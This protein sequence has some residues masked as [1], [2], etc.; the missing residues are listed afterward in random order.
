MDH[1]HPTSSSLNSHSSMTS[2]AS[3][4]SLTTSSYNTVSGMSSG[5]TS[6]TSVGS[7][8]FKSSL[9]SSKFLLFW[10][11]S[12]M[13]MKMS[14]DLPVLH[15]CGCFICCHKPSVP[16]Y[17]KYVYISD[18]DLACWLQTSK[19]LTPEIERLWLFLSSVS[20]LPKWACGCTWNHELSHSYCMCAHS[21]HIIAM[22]SLHAVTT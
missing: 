5:L 14:L 2:N 9:T 1:S 19:I 4:S 17:M 15:A 10:V 3:T 22:D 7:S 13:F 11:V 18:L 21:F 20:S 16:W 12:I 8:A 6:V